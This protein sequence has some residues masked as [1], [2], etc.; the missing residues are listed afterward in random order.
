MKNLLRFTL[1]GA[2]LTGSVLLLAPNS[3]VGYS[4]LGQQLGIG[5][6][7]HRL[8]NNFTASGANNNTATIA[9]MP[10]YDGAELAMWKAGAEWGARV[11]GDGTGD[12]T[13]T[14]L[15]DGLASFNFYWNGNASGIGG[16]NDNIHS[17][18][19]GSSGGVLAFTETPIDNGWRIRYY[20]TWSWQDGPGSVTSGIDLQG[21]ACHELGHALGLGH[22]TVGGATMF[23]SISGT[24][25]VTRSI[26]TDDK[27]GAQA[28]YGA[29]NA[30]MPRINTVTG[31][32]VP[33]G[34][35]VITG[36]GFT[37]DNKVWLDNDLIDGG[38]AGG[39]PFKIEGLASTGGGTQI[40]FTLPASGYVGGSIHVKDGTNN[41]FWSLSEG[42]PF[43]AL[44][45]PITDTVSLTST[46]LTPPVGSSVTFTISAAPGF[47][48]YIL[49]YAF[50]NT[51]TTINGQPFD[52]GPPDGTVSSGT[53]DILGGASV[54]RI[55][56]VGGAGRTVYME[57]QV[58][59]G[60]V[61][62]DSNMI[63][64]VVP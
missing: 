47:S 57:T 1:G 6:R 39:E 17:E 33:G 23:P 40:T 63:T 45:G 13:Q 25:Q 42:H 4:L 18:I 19:P 41:D 15:G 64:L 29:T 16:T 54:T 14:Q 9:N 61:T 59:S 53:T 49:H 5:Q 20:G 11:F 12:S 31:S 60:G 44:G 51:G 56:P 36:S 3:A 30:A 38:N 7:D 62:Y 35:V 50:T 10:A 58:D 8:F 22:S 2:V 52:I 24:G 21:V 34:T 43:D 48:P 28:N 46:S 27:N 26:E 55:V 37:A 32:L